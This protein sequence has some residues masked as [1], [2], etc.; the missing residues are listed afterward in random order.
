ML[1]WRSGGFRTCDFVKILNEHI[2]DLS[3]HSQLRG[4][5]C[6]HRHFHMF[7]LFLPR[8]CE[9]HASPFDVWN[10]RNNDDIKFSFKEGRWAWFDVGCEKH[11][12]FSPLIIS[13]NAIALYVGYNFVISIRSNDMF[14]PMTKWH[15]VDSF[16]H[17]HR[18]AFEYSQFANCQWRASMCEL[19]ELDL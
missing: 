1:F 11:E 3:S 5:W 16:S 9:F 2:A 14:I 15:Q 17:T 7:W 19:L 12:N 8:Y 10:C 6:R 18:K 4:F 13:I